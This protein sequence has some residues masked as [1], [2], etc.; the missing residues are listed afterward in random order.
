MPKRPNQTDHSAG[1]DVG[2]GKPPKTSQFK[3][4]VSG[5]PSGRKPNQ[6][7]VAYGPGALGAAIQKELGRKTKVRDGDRV[8]ILTRADVVARKVV[9][10]AMTGS[11]SASETILRLESRL[12]PP[13]YKPTGPVKVTLKLGEEPPWHVRNNLNDSD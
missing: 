2:Y 9:H 10:S 8:R 5:N 12:P 7:Q 11:G 1:Y 3:K 13:P 6:E 4:G